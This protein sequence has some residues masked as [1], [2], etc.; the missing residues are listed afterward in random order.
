M[1]QVASDQIVFNVSHTHCGP[2]AA[3]TDYASEVAAKTVELV[4]SCLEG[5]TSSSVCRQ[6]RAPIGVNRRRKSRD[7]TVLWGVNP[8]GPVDHGY[9]H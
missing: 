6:G 3:D 2:S 7:G 4:K 8:Y 9:G 5:G 1:G